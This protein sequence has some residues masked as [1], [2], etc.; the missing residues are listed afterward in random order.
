MEPDQSSDSNSEI[1]Q[2]LVPSP[3]SSTSD[4]AERKRKRRGIHLMPRQRAR[5]RKMVHVGNLRCEVESLRSENNK[6]HRI[7]K[8]NFES[9][10]RVLEDNSKLRQEASHFRL[11][12]GN[13]LLQRWLFTFIIMNLVMLFFL[14]RPPMKPPGK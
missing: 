1:I 2:N 3:P 13:D 14:P 6:L 5:W 10:L 9:H 11:F 7:L 4:E 12:A 8:L